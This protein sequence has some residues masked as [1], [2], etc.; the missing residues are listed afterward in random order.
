MNILQYIIIITSLLSITLILI[1][2]NQVIKNNVNNKLAKYRSKDEGFVDLLNYAS[3]IEPGIILNKN[4]SLMSSFI[5]KGED[6][7]SATIAQRNNV[8]AKI[9]QALYRLGSGWMIH[10]DAVRRPA[11]KYSSSDESYFTDEL[12]AAI[13]EERRRFFNG[14]GEMYEGYFILTITYLPPVLAQQ[15]FVEMMF[16]DDERKSKNKTI[17]GKAVISSFIRECNNIQSSLSAVVKIEKLSNYE[18]VTEDGRTVTYDDQLRWLQFCVTNENHPIVLPDTPIF[19]DKLIGGKE[20]YS[21]VIP[22]IGD[23]FIQVISIDG[24][25]IESYPGILTILAEQPCEYRWSNR[26]IFLD[27]HEAISNL[28]KYRKKWKQKVRGFFDQVFNINSGKIN[29]DASLMVDDADNAIAE[30]ESGLVCSGYYTSVI[31][32]MD[33]NRSKLESNVQIIKKA[34]NTTGFSARVETINTV[35]AFLGSLPGH[36]V[37]NIRRPLINSLNLSHLIPTSSIWSG[38]EIAPCPFYKKAPALMHAVT[39]GSTP[40]RLNLHVGDLGHTIMFGPTGA[41][42]ST[43]L[44]LLAAQFRRYKNMKIFAFDKGNSLYALAAGIRAKT[45]GKSGLHFEIGADKNQLS[46][47]PLQFLDSRSYRAWAAEWIDTVLALNGLKTTAK[48]RNSIAETLLN[49]YENGGKTIT[50]FTHAIQDNQIRETLEQYTIDGAM[51]Y[52]L[53]ADDDGLLLSDF[54]V[55][56][57]EELMNFDNKY[58]LPV[59]LYL[60]KRIEMSLTGDPAV[61]FIDEA[62]MAL[63]DS[64]FR[65]K[66]REWLKVLRKANALVFMATQSISDAE[67]SGILDVLV[68]ATA[69]KIFLPNIAA[70]DEENSKIYARMGLNTR[71]IDIISNAIPKRQYYLV[72]SNGRRLYDLA[73]GPLALSFVAASDK[74]SVSEIKRLEKEFG[75]EWVNEWLK[76]KGLILENYIEGIST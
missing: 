17:H 27:K 39:S 32:L 61:I 67:N 5:Y 22:K 52:L 74:E 26:F 18:V 2:F 7:A 51:G 11:N 47:C 54:S 71:Q 24:F 10:V 40:F 28:N 64:A 43:H 45:G 44:A 3:E 20:F 33:K 37:E 63:G 1:L 65:G 4:G 31:V 25:P 69:T 21:G 58:S 66:L 49:M 42:K 41:G 62:W 12:T 23:K 36:G 46:F 76:K 48:Q 50:D 19:L 29:K 73:L 6:N 13:D 57:I 70:R 14:L 30:L 72:S 75:N 9:N 15:K 38:S 34:I 35:D 55:F 8:A 53:D 60:F 16:D 68:E 56:E 59:L